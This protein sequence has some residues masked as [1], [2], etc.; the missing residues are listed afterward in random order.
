MSRYA[1]ALEP[2][3]ADPWEERN[4]RPFAVLESAPTWALAVF[5]GAA[6]SALWSLYCLLGCPWVPG[7]IS[8]EKRSALLQVPWLHAVILVVGSAIAA[9]VLRRLRKGHQRST[10]P[11]RL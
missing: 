10:T 2:G 9:V 11:D 6:G 4:G 3:F 7:F 1:R 8:P 5:G